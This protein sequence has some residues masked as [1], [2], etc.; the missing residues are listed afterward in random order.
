MIGADDKIE[1]RDVALGPA[2]QQAMTVLSGLSSGDRLAVGDFA[3][4]HF[5]GLLEIQP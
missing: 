2:T 4:L 5:A 1:K 3:K